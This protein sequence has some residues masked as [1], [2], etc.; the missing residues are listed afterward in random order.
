MQLLWYI[1]EYLKE[2]KKNEWI[3][4][5]EK[6]NSEFKPAVLHLKIDLVSL[7]VCG[8][9][10]YQ[11]DTS[12]LIQNQDF[13]LRMMLSIKGRVKSCR[14]PPSS[15]EW[16]DLTSNQVDIWHKVI[17]LWAGTHKSRFRHQIINWSLQN[18]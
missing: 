9:E 17:L 10:V 16:R 14:R 4:R 7:L 6:E 3:V 11:T 5:P 1:S 15:R 2:K 8:G 12:R 18:W 13:V